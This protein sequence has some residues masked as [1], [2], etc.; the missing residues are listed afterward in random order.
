MAIVSNENRRSVLIVILPDRV[1]L[2]VPA[3]DVPRGQSRS[4]DTHTAHH[5]DINNAPSTRAQYPKHL[6]ACQGG[7]ARLRVELG[8]GPPPRG[9]RPSG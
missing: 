5:C 2:R 3:F 6:D 9:S 4:Q 8:L 1:V 7:L